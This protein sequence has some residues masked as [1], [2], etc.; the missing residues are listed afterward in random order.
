MTKRTK[1]AFVAILYALKNTFGLNP[2]RIISDYKGGLHAASKFVYP[3]SKVTGCYFHYAQ[4]KTTNLLVIQNCLMLQVCILFL[5]TVIS[6]FV[7]QAVYKKAH[8]R[9]SS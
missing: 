4:V 5:F 2:A 7:Y 8:S 3:L 9:P 6:N 1:N